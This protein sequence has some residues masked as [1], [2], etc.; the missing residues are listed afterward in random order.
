[1]YDSADWCL[2]DVA[3]LSEETCPQLDANNAEDEEDEKAQQ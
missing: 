2:R 3:P 1:M